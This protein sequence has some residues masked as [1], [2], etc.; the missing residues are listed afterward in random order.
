VPDYDDDHYYYA[1][2]TMQHGGYYD[3]DLFIYLLILVYLTISVA[4]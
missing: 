4:L 2:E 3:T 1:I